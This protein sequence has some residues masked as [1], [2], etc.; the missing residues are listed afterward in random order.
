MRCEAADFVVVGRTSGE[1]LYEVFEW[2]YKESK[3]P[4]GQLI[5][6]LGSWIHL[7]LGEPFREK[8]RCREVFTYREDAFGKRLYR[9]LF[10]VAP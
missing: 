8:E 2:I 3:I 5:Y 9:R 7:S 10:D 4:F 1:L 6:E